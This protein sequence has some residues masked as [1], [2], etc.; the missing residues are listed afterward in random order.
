MHVKV[1]AAWRVILLA[2]V[3]AAGCTGR[4]PATRTDTAPQAEAVPPLDMD[5]YAQWLRNNS[6]ADFESY[7]AEFQ[8]AGVVPT[9]ELL[10][11]ATDWKK[12]GGPEFEIPPREHWPDVRKVLS[13]VSELKARRI[14]VDFEAVS[15]FRNAQLNACAGGARQSAH[16]QSFA[17]DIISRSGKVDE[18][19][20]CEFWRTEGKTWEMGLARYPSGRIHLD[21]TRHRTWGSDHRNGTSFCGQPPG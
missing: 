5:A 3:V 13:L 16:T 8:L 19:L 15:N 11:T 9:P 2:A 1:P 20:L 4:T 14:L 18:K 17:V 7:L 12:C 10:R 6:V 21:T